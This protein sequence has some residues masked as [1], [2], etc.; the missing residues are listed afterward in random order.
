MPKSIRSPDH[1][2]IP[3]KGEYYE[4]DLLIPWSNVSANYSIGSASYSGKGKA[5][6]DHADTLDDAL[7]GC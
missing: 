3:K 5:Q 2:I 7:T 6:L 4:G 1:K